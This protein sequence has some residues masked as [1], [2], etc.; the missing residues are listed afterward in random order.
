MDVARAESDL[1][2]LIERRA[3]EASERRSE[4]M[5]W[6]ESVRRHNAKLRRQHRAEW[7]AHFSNLAAAFRAS[8]DQFDRKAEALLEDGAE[9]SK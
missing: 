7:F 5:L 6:K 3:R 9:G 4:E 8:A 1:N 2:A